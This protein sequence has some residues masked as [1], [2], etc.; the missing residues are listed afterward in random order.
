LIREAPNKPA[1]LQAVQ[2][3]R[4]MRGGSQAHLIRASDNNLYITKFQNNP[5][6]VRVLANEYLGSKLG[7]LLN[8][9][10]PEARIME[11]SDWLIEN[12]PELRIDISPRSVPCVSGLQFASRYAGDPEQDRIFDYLPDSMFHRIANSDDFPRMLVFDK[13]TGN[14]D[15]RQAVFVQRPPRRTYEA[16]FIDQ[17]YC[18]NA[19][20][21]DF[22]DSPLRGTYARNSVYE[23]VTDWQSFE[24][25][26]SWIEQ[27]GI[28][29][30]WKIATEAPEEWYEHDFEGM[31]TLIEALHARRSLVRK[32][33]TSFRNS[34]RNPFPNWK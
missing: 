30:L 21:W 2:H 9:P 8:L 17:G 26:L 29:E 22:P 19:G 32:L 14:S 12:T 3:I 27:M 13:W 33:I 24:P 7:R 4:K 34:T 10:M 15:G 20:E 23:G 28:D 16:L 6:H 1:P 31:T 5:Q 18:F 11:V 25:T